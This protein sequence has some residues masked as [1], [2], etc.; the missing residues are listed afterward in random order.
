MP[1]NRSKEQ[2]NTCN[3]VKHWFDNARLNPEAAAFAPPKEPATDVKEVQTVPKVLHS[4]NKNGP[5]AL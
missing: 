1:A 4:E 3:E 2:Q 5:H